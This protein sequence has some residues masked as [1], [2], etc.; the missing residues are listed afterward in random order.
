[1][2]GEKFVGENPEKTKENIKNFFQ[3]LN[4][5]IE[6]INIKDPN[7]HQQIIIWPILPTDGSLK[8]DSIYSVSELEKDPWY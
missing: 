7:Y 1:M 4:S 5:K 3:N 8:E 2:Y 6:I